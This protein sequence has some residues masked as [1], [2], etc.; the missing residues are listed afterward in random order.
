MPRSTEPVRGAA[1]LA[2]LLT[3]VTSGACA[4]APAPTPA[5]DGGDAGEIAAPLPPPA[6]AVLPPS[7]P[8]S[9]PLP[10]PSLSGAEASPPLPSIRCLKGM[11]GVAGRFCVDPW[12]ASLIDKAT[13][14]PLSPYYPPERKF[15]IQLAERWERQ[16][17][18]MGDAEAQ[19]ISLP[20]LPA[21]QREHDPEPMAVSKPGVV[22]NGYLSGL[23]AARA[24]EN[25][26]KRLCRAD[27]W[28][29]ACEGEAKQRF[30]YGARYAQGACNIF[31]EVH[32]GAAL[33][34]NA[35]VGLLDPRMNLVVD[36]GGDP[37]LH[38]TGGTER[39]K[40][41]WGHEAAYDM[42]GN[43]D[44]WVLDNELGPDPETGWRGRMAGGFF[45][46]AKRDGCASGVIV[47]PKTYLDYSTGARCCWSP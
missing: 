15:A 4:P 42:N 11:L 7:P 31:R 30:P 8:V 5:L 25:A 44:E 34:R 6:S 43:L 23:M 3:L 41:V 2:L 10:P 26:G 18:L 47:H 39:C 24:C 22:P 29:L 46:R 16:R 17:L 14:T 13:G 40:S 37:L 12:E 21:W 36:S 27:E 19:A 28:K 32:P 20:E 1:P 45:S 35:S 33:H 9:A 38:L